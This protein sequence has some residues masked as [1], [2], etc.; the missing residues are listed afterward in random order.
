MFGIISLGAFAGVVVATILIFLAYFMNKSI[1]IPYIIFFV[2]VIVFG[3]STFLF[4]AGSNETLENPSTQPSHSSPEDIPSH[5]GVSTPS[6][7]LQ[8]DNTPSDSTPETITVICNLS[9]FSRISTNELF[10]IMGG[11]WVKDPYGLS[12]TTSVGEK[13]HGDIYIFEG[14]QMEFVVVENQVVRATYNAPKYY[15]ISEESI[16]YDQKSD[17]PLMFGVTPDSHTK[18]ISETPLAY[19]LSPVNDSVADFWVTLMDADAKT[20]EQVKATY[21][22]RYIG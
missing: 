14:Q 15:D 10:N 1:V 9:Q 3:V 22:L 18:I 8:P 13:V 4:I 20:F 21:D 11:D 17:I 19:R 5:E 16:P 6:E 7:S 12:L 2:F